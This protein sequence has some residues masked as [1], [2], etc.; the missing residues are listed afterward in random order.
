MRMKVLTQFVGALM[1]FSCAQ[2][3][4]P[5]ENEAV[6]SPVQDDT[7]EVKTA[8]ASQEVLAYPI[9]AQGTVE[10]RRFTPII[11]EVAGVL[12]SVNI[13]NANYVHKG[14]LVA[15][16]D[17]RLQKIQVEEASVEFER[18]RA[19]F[20]N[21]LAEFGDSTNYP[22][23]WSRIK[24]KVALL[25]G[26]PGAKVALERAKFNLERTEFRAPYSGLIEGFE[27][28]TGESVQAMTAIGR[29]VDRNSL[30]VL[31]NVLEFDLGKLG[32]GDSAAIFPLAYPGE[33]VLARVREINPKV[34]ETGYV[35]VRLA[36]SDLNNLLDGMS[37]RVE[38]YVPESK[39]ILVPKS[40]V[41]HKSG[42]NVV[43]TV[44][45]SLAKW[46]YVTVGKENG[47]QVE[48]LEGLEPD[49]EVIISN[50]LQ[51]A[52]DSPVKVSAKNP[53]P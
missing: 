36:I 19:D 41:V 15:A 42:R 17:N 43:F 26:L 48:I 8:S 9:Q 25:T 32:V 51:L 33:Q 6:N 24:E 31:C 34:E 37:G 27:L 38:I 45:E 18:A 23:N 39:Q 53:S 3:S 30:E 1:L 44:E 16:L 12:K 52:H 14:D 11:F 4:N 28:R 22:A 50:N 49:D 47:R 13:G 2:N 7:Y 46:H 10:A 5:K 21:K 29:I 20:E 40:A 35:K